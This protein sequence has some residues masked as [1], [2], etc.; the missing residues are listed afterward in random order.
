[1]KDIQPVE[2]CNASV[3]ISKLNT[4]QRRSL[5]NDP[6]G[7]Y[8]ATR[9]LSS[10]LFFNA[11]VQTLSQLA[12]LNQIGKF[13]YSPNSTTVLPGVWYYRQ[14]KRPQIKKETFCW[15]L[16]LCPIHWTIRLYIKM[17]RKTMLSTGIRIHT[18]NCD[19][20]Q[21]TCTKQLHLINMALGIFHTSQGFSDISQRD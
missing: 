3:S 16:W 19:R 17:K 2:L 18:T 5:R 21:T 1:M 4:R 6:K 12:H 20:L 10:E 11:T 15:E 13:S 8:W 14:A 7:N 9:K